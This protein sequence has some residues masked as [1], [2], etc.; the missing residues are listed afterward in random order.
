MKIFP[1]DISS[2]EEETGFTLEKAKTGYGNINGTDEEVTIVI[3]SLSGNRRYIKVDKGY[4]LQELESIKA[5]EQL[6]S[7][8][9][10]QEL[11]LDLD[12]VR[13]A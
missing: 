1:D 9:P 10:I 2:E 8:K 5:P 7:W 6:D 13:K 3:K 12:E 11:P 4:M